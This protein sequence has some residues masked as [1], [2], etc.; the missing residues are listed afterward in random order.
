MDLEIKDKILAARQEYVN[1]LIAIATSPI[2]AAG[3]VIQASRLLEKTLKEME[4]AEA[5]LQE[6]ERGEGSDVLVINI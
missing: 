4:A 3:Q 1:Q 5:L 2:T 6:E